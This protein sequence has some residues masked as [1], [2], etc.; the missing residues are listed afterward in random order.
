MTFEQ[1]T[2]QANQLNEIIVEYILTIKYFVVTVWDSQYEKQYETVLI[3]SKYELKYSEADYSLQLAFKRVS[4]KSLLI[5]YTTADSWVTNFDALSIE[6]E[7]LN[8]YLNPK[9]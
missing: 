9:P 7:E 6:D 2:E 1:A 3:P 5:E 8:N 4:I